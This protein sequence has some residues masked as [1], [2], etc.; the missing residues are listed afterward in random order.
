MDWFR[1]WHGAPTD[2]KW[3]VIGKRAKVAPGMVSAVAWALLD[4]ASQNSDRGSVEGFD[5][6]TYAM[7]TGWD[8][9]QVEAVI[10]AMQSKGVI[11]EDGRLASWEKR[12]PKRED[13]DST[14]RVRRHRETKRNALQER[15]ND[16]TDDV[17][18]GNAMK[19]DVTQSN[20]RTEKNREEKNR[21]EQTDPV[22]V[23]V[24]AW[25]SLGLTINPFTF[26]QLTEA[27]DEWSGAGHPEYVAQAIA[28]AG[29]HNARSWAYV[30][31]ILR[32]CRDEGKPPSY[33]NG[34]TEKADAPL[35]PVKYDVVWSD[36]T[37]EEVEVMTRA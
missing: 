28:E 32:R 21:T 5:V 2:N 9:S 20:D 17:T 23:A 16:V 33:T 27:V 36:G 37:T 15:D 7:F 18:Q 13:P 25:E 8:E 6:E 3:L 14:E 12:Q 4:Y 35:V 26:Q 11:T 34:K 29:R 22:A 30:E 10:G 31:G 24:A 19:R 1:S